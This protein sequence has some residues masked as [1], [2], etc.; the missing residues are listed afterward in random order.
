M[1]FKESDQGAY[2]CEAL[3][4]QGSVFAIP[5]TILVVKAN[6]TV[7]PQGTFNELA[8]SYDECIPCFCF[9]I[10]TSCRSAD[11]FVY[12]VGL[13]LFSL[14]FDSL[15]VTRFFAFL[16]LFYGAIILLDKFNELIYLN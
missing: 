16:R 1:I 7:C 10:T 14:P 8:T 2:S 12:Q 6:R 9:G 3:N 5:D 11:L 4:N 15:V 13:S